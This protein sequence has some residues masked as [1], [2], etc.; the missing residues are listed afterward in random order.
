LI[1]FP[2][3]KRRINIQIS[4]QHKQIYLS[5]VKFSIQTTF[6]DQKKQNTA[7]EDVIQAARA[8]KLPLFTLDQSLNFARYRNYCYQTCKFNFLPM[9]VAGKPEKIVW[10]KTN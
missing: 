5:L 8:I 4:L 1:A 2:T 10:Q 6:T 3:E 9:S 7:D